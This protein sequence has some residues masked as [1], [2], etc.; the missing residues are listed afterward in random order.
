MKESATYQAI[1]ADGMHHILLHHGRMLFDDPDAETRAALEAITDP[2]QLERLSER[3]LDV[4][5]WDELLAPSRPRWTGCKR[6][7]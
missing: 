3:L 7:R 6:G 5:S 1:L 2:Q 4:S